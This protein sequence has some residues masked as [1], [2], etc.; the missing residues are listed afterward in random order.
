MLELIKKHKCSCV[1]EAQVRSIANHCRPDKQSTWFY[2]VMCWR[3]T[4]LHFVSCSP[5]VQCHVPEAHWATRARHS[6]RPGAHRAGRHRRGERR[7]HADRPSL[8]ARPSQVEL[9][10]LQPRQV[11]NRRAELLVLYC[12]LFTLFEL[13]FLFVA[14]GSVLIF[15][16]RKANCVELQ[17]NLKTRDFKGK[18]NF[19]SRI[20]HYWGLMIFKCMYVSW[21]TAWRYESD[22]AKW[23]HKRVQEAGNAGVGRDGRSRCVKVGVGIIILSIRKQ[24]FFAARGLD[25]PHIRTVVNFDIARDIDTH[26]HRVGRTGR[27]GMKY[28]YMYN[29][30]PLNLIASF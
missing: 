20:I 24:R 28:M 5:V 3:L 9:A 1:S 6:Q 2:V 16:T 26:T 25:I 17:T 8:P 29:L 19:I 10:Q 18:Q 13:D 15:V 22:G 4:S 14:V 23:R 7:R 11:H 27:A 30:F 12:C 21:I